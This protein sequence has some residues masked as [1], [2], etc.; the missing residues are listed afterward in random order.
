MNNFVAVKIIHTLGDLLSPTNNTLN[1]HGRIVMNYV[2]E[3][4][5]WTIFH[6]NGVPWTINRNSPRKKRKTYDKIHL[7]KFKMGLRE[8]GNKF[9]FDIVKV[10]IAS[11]LIG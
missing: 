9:S 6:E 8:M 5:I 7:N 11:I 2:K 10:H 4:S 1:A 3:V